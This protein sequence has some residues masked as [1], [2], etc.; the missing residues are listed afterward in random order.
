MPITREKK[1]E[2]I[3]QLKTEAASAPAVVFVNFHGLNVARATELRKTLK[4]QAVNYVV[5]K[6]TLIKKAFEGATVTGEMPELD[7]EVALA[8]GQDQLAPAKGLYDFEKKNKDS[9]KM[10]GGIFEGAYV[11][12]TMVMSLAMIPGREVLYG[13]FVNLLNSP[14]Q[15]LVMALNQICE[16]RGL[17]VS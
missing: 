14:I 8:F 11:D 10:L 1:A 3:K 15:R 9:L 6:K 2:I 13:K 4:A 5:A 16:K 17:P 7:G 12:A